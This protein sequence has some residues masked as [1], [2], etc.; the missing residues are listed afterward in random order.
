MSWN[1]LP[2]HII[3]QALIED[4]SVDSFKNVIKRMS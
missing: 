3:D 2:N 1:N 4:V